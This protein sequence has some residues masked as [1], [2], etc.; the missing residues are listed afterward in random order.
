[1]DGGEDTIWEHMLRAVEFTLEHRGPHGL[2]RS[3]FSDW[4]DTLNVDHGSGK[5]ESV[6][7]AMQFC[8]A[9]LDLA[10]LCEQL[11]RL[12]EAERFRDSAR[13]DGRGRSTSCAWDGAW[14]ARSFDDDGQPIGVAGA[15]AP[16]H[17]PQHRRAGP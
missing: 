16:R 2:P 17:R 8:R 9:M 15:A 10:E 4:D 14:Y 13:R 12:D 11:G 5:A 3:G 1:M 6:W 7:T